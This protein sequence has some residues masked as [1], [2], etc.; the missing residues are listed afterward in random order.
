V[1]R[2]EVDIGEVAARTVIIATGVTWR[3]LGVPRLEDLQGKGV[4][5][6]AGGA[7]ARATQGQHVCVVGA[8][9]SA[10]QATVNLARTA[11][12]VTMLVRGDDLSSS[13]SDYLVQEIMRTPNI[14]VRFHTEIVDGHGNGR[15]ERLVLRDKRRG[16]TAEL[17]AAALFILIGAEPR[18]DWLTGTVQRDAKGYLLTGDTVV[19][20]TLGPAAWP[21]PRP[22]ML[23]ESSRPG[24]FAVGDVRNGSVK[25]VA[26]A[27][28]E[29]S[30]AVRLAHEY[31]EAQRAGSA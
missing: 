4:F 31:L 23:F 18:T 2:S 8:G 5:Y 26:S 3:R 25:R 24:V 7:E 27:V 19:R 11:R 22:P 28:G 21:L 6:G 12:S 30:V 10:G 17:D 1:R 14:A 29:G 15:L 20:T 9:N 13:M 16:S